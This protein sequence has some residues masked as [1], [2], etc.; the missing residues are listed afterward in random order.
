MGNEEGGTALDQAFEATMMST[1]ALEYTVGQAIL[2]QPSLVAAPPGIPDAA[3][4]REAAKDMHKAVGDLIA[5]AQ[6]NMEKEDSVDISHA[7]EIFSRTM[8]SKAALDAMEHMRKMRECQ[9]GE[10]DPWYCWREFGI[11]IFPYPRPLHPDWYK[12]MTVSEAWGQVHADAVGL[13]K[14][15][16]LKMQAWEPLR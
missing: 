2:K 15:L 6:A 3:A 10:G 14:A 4:L 12:E 1:T 5:I 13:L 7:A 8:K 16:E 9:E 11:W